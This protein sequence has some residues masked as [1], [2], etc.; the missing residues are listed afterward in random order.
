MVSTQLVNALH[1]TSRFEPLTHEVA[2]DR[3]V[4][5]AG[6]PPAWNEA[7]ITESLQAHGWLSR[8]RSSQLA[9]SVLEINILRTSS[10][11]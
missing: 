11:F 10:A 1:G 2:P 5:L 9:D 7:G 3:P 4:M 6:P 8:S